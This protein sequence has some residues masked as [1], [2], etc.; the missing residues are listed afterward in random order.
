MTDRIS[1]AVE[2][3]GAEK[4]V[5]VP[6]P[7]GSGSEERTEPNIE[8][9]I[10]AILSLE[11]IAQDSTIHDKGRDHVRVME[12]LCAYVRENSN[13]RKPVDYPEPEWVPMPEDIT[14][15]RERE[16]AEA[17]IERFGRALR[18]ES[19]VKSWVRT[20]MK[21]RA[22]VALALRVIGRR[23][24]VQRAVEAAWPSPPEAAT[25][26]PFD[27]PC[28]HLPDE[29]EKVPLSESSFL[30]FRSALDAWKGRIE[31]YTGYRLD[32][33]GA[34]LQCVELNA[35]RPDGSDAIFS[36]AV[37][38]EARMEGANLGGA[39][40]EGAFL[41]QAHLEGADLSEAR[42][43]A[44]T[45][46]Q[47]RMEGANLRHAWM[48]GADCIEAHLAG[49]S[50]GFAR[51]EASRLIGAQLESVSFLKTRLE[52]ASLRKANMQ[53]A[54]LWMVSMQ[55]ADLT[56][57]RME[58]ATLTKVRMERVTPAFASLQG[59]LISQGRLAGLEEL[60]HLTLG[61]AA[62]RWIDLS[63]LD[64]FPGQI[65]TTFGDAGVSLH[66]KV[67][68]PAHWPDWALPNSGSHG[69]Y[70]EW[71]KWQADPDGYV[72]PPRPAEGTEG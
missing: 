3:L 69:F 15:E 52:G 12:I 14:A 54:D 53:A 11:R 60:Q 62:F 57:T 2:Q 13:A 4:T 23:T 7:D 17:R 18:G 24:A 72:P 30:A 1:K 65:E 16:R 27:L 67:A 26:W 44:A 29:P 8:V 66:D 70:T 28:P 50:L 49:A 19:K 47:A 33:T 9:R 34:N 61:G 71:R 10:G 37:L 41:L 64:F 5:K 48:L 68:R 46:G 58:G 40:L 56:Q 6:R 63:E 21:P 55:G 35:L 22:D 36:G 31:G 32:L 59:A 51:L 45:L 20:L 43:E 38:L 39:R 42:L 25:V